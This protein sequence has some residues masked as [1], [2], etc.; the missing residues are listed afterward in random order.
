VQA[1]PGPLNQS[2]STDKRVGNC[3]LTYGYVICIWRQARGLACDAQTGYCI[4][5]RRSLRAVCL[6]EL[7]GAACVMPCVLAQAGAP[8]GL[9]CALCGTTTQRRGRRSPS[10]P[11]P[12]LP[13]RQWQ[14]CRGQNIGAEA[15]VAHGA[16]MP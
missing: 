10:P 3:V 7:P 4:S 16:A 11:W 13:A 15:Q 2:H 6:R 9:D 8:N 14:A 1:H 12:P 5:S